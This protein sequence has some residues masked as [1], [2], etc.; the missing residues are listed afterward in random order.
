MHRVPS[1][2]SGINCVTHILV[3]LQQEKISLVLRLSSLPAGCRKESTDLL[4][5][6]SILTFAPS[7][8]L[9]YLFADSTTLTLRV[10]FF[11]LLFRLY[12]DYEIVPIDNI[13][14]HAT[15]VL[16]LW[17]ESLLFAC[18]TISSDVTTRTHTETKDHG[19]PERFSGLFCVISL[20]SH[21][22][23][24]LQILT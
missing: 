1:E 19:A 13:Y 3:L 18:F 17:V 12:P 20:I 7:Y 22:S 21:D 14:T 10:D 9:F 8:C 2:T 23:V 11:L 16:F 15:K 24:L 6:E 4:F 5:V